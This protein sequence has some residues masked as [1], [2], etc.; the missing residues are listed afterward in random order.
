MRIDV[1]NV[2]TVML[3]F[4]SIPKTLVVNFTGRISSPNL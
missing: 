4:I 2:K 3:D 1:A